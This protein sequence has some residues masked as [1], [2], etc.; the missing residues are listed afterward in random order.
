M[1][2]AN[3]RSRELRGTSLFRGWAV[4]PKTKGASR[5]HQHVLSIHGAGTERRPRLLRSVARSNAYAAQHKA[6]VR[7][8]GEPEALIVAIFPVHLLET[9]LCSQRENHEGRFVCFG[10]R[11]RASE[12]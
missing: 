10:R 11:R 8:F 1:R 7:F 5:H 6:Y 9:L 4:S 3:K 2:T 12:R